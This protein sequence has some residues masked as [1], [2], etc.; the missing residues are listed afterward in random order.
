MQAQFGSNA[1][2]A[3]SPAQAAP[4]ARTG[5]SATPKQERES[6]SS[7]G[8]QIDTKKRQWTVPTDEDKSDRSPETVSQPAR[9]IA[10]E[11]K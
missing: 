4:R 2:K 6:V 8:K 10:E 1:G 9:P 11:R 7:N 5:G 3:A